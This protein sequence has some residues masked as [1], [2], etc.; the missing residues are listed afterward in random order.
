MAKLAIPWVDKT[1]AILASLPFAVELYRRWMGGHVNFPRAV[2]GVQLL[3]LILLMV[4]R[5]APVR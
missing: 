1:I 5:T 4:L 3:V 2:L